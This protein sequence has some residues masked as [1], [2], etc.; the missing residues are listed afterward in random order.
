[1]RRRA[2]LTMALIAL[3]TAGC[4]GTA[5]H[6]T[7]ST[8]E[9]NGEIT[10]T[11]RMVGGPAPGRRLLGHTGVRVYAGGSVVRDMTTD[12]EGRFDLVLPAGRYR[13]TLRNGSELLPRHVDV[14]AGETGRLR[15]TLSVK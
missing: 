15:L 8:G 9:R 7:R 6:V 13:L 14:T 10:G 5:D 3:G 4:G 1:M 2:G 12:A 11:L